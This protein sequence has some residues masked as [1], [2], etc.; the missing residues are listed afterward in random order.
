MITVK[1]A[2]VSA[3]SFVADLFANA[4]DLRL[5]QVEMFGSSW[6]IVISFKLS[7]PS[8][9]LLAMGGSNRIFKEVDVD[10]ESGEATALRMFKT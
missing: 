9:L 6:R 5:E 8:T 3:T 1:Q 4:Q 7:E 10:R 2:V